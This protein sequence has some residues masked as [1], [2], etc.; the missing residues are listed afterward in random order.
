MTAKYWHIRIREQ[1]E[2]KK[3]RYGRII[4]RVHD[5][6]RKGHSKRVAGIL[7][8]GKW[9]TYSY[10]ISKKDAKLEN[11]ELKATD[12]TVARTLAMIR[13]RYGEIYHKYDYHFG[14]RKK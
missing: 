8:N 9:A 5:I 12:P 13:Y 3:D 14:V 6:G 10:L 1:S 11:G 7:K 4:L 2:F